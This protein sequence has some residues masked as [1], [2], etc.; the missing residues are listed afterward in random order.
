M[1][2]G[3]EINWEKVAPPSQRITFLGVDIDTVSRTLALPES[4]LNELKELIDSWMTKKRVSKRDLL[5]LCGKLNWACRVVRGGRTFLCRLVDLSC[6]LHK[7]HHRIWLNTE[8]RED[9][10]WWLFGLKHFHG[11]TRFTGDLLPP[12]TALA[13][14]SCKVS[15]GGTYEH[16]WFYVD[17]RADFPGWCDQ[18]INV[19]ELLTVLIAVRRWGHLWK[20]RHIQI[21]CDNSSSV[22]A[23]NKGT[24][25]SPVFMRILREIFWHSVQHDFRFSAIHV[26]GETNVIA[27]TISR[28]SFPGYFYKFVNMF[29]PA[30][31]VFNCFNHMSSRSFLFLQGSIRK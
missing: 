30:I 9:I 5:K 15:G 6:R 21:K 2:L 8:A 14:D 24:S 3:L 10:K 28:L 7:N 4:K 26:K 23:I 13:T 27:D 29:G 31:R 1:K 16:D 11:Y 22:S 18:H 25:R 20:D 12:S 17:F 19:L